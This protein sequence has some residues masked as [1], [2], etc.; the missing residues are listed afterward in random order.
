MNKTVSQ[1]IEEL[2]STGKCQIKG[3]G[4]FTTK[5][6]KGREG[7]N[8]LTGKP[9]KTEDKIVIAFKPSKSLDTTSFPVK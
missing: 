4:T 6:R 7:V 3:F 5:V 8:A 1:I 9:F 2:S